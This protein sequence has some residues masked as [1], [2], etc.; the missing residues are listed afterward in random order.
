MKNLFFLWVIGLLILTH[1]AQATN[2]SGTYTV[3]AGGDFT[4]LTAVSNAV[5][6]SSGNQITGNV[7]FEIRSDYNTASETFPIVLRAFTATNPVYTVTIRPRS[8]AGSVLTTGS[9]SSAIISLDEGD[10]YILDGR[11]GGSGSAIW[12]LRNTRSSTTYGAVIRLLNGATYNTMTYLTLESQNATTGSGDIY[13]Q[14]TGNTT[15]NSY[16]T[17]SYCIV[18]NRSDVAGTN[19]TT[20]I[21]ASGNTTYPNTNNTIDNCEF[22][23]HFNAASYSNGIYIY[24]G[25]TAYTITNNKIYQPSTLTYTTGT[26][27]FGIRVYNSAGDGF[28]ISDNTIGFANNSGTGTYTM[29]GAV[30]TQFM[31]IYL[32]LGTG[33]ASSVQGNRIGGISLSSTYSSNNVLSGIYASGM[34][35]IG[36]E[37]GNYIGDTTSATSI[38]V[39]KA[40]ASTSM[41]YVCGILATTASTVN[42]SN[43]CISGITYTSTDATSGLRIFG[44]YST[45]SGGNFTVKANKI[46][47]V[48]TANNIQLGVSGSTTGQGGLMGILNGASGTVT[49]SNNTIANITNYCS[50][51]YYSMGIY[52]FSGLNA[53]NQNQILKIKTYS[54]R[55]GNASSAAVTG[56]VKSSTISGAHSVNQNLIYD[57]SCQ[58][59]T[60]NNYAVGIFYGGPVDGAQEVNRNRI[61][62]L[63]AATTGTTGYA[64]G[65]YVASGNANTERNFIHSLSSTSSTL[66]L[67]GIRIAGGTGSV[68]NNKVQL[69]IDGSGNS[70]TS[71]IY[72]YGIYKSGSSANNVYHNSVY[73]GG[74]GVAST[75]VNTMAFYRSVNTTVDE[76]SNNIFVNNR[77]NS[78]TGGKHF[79]Y[80]LNG[81]STAHCDYNLYHYTGTG[82]YLASLNNGTTSRSTLREVRENYSSQEL[83]SAFGN[84]G[85][86]TPTGT[87]STVDLN[88]SGT[89]AAEASGLN[90]ASVTTDFNGDTRASFSPVD[91]GADAGSFTSSDI[92]TPTVSYL[93][94]N[95]TSS[96]SNRT[97][98]GVTIEDQGTGVPTSGGNV[99]TVWYRIS[100]GTPTAWVYNAGT[101]SSGSGNSGTWSFVIDYSKLSRS[102]ASSDVIQYYIVAQDQATSPNLWYSPFIGASHTSVTSQTTAPSTPNS[103][104]ISSASLSGTYTIGSGGDYATLSAAGGFFATANSNSIS[105]NITLNIISNITE[106]GANALNAMSMGGNSYSIT[107]QPSAAVER[108]ISGSVTT[109]LVRLSGVDSVYIDGSYGGAGRYLRFRNTSTSTSHPACISFTNSSSY[110]KVQNCYL[111]G[112]TNN[113]TIN[114]GAG[115]SVSGNNY[116]TIDNNII[117]NR[118]DLVQNPT[119][120]IYSIGTGTTGLE[121]KENIITNNEIFNY[122]T[123]GVY[124]NGTGNGNHWTIDGN[125][126]YNNLATAPAVA[127]Y[128]IYIGSSNSNNNVITDNYIGGQAASCGGSAYT[129]TGNINFFPIYLYAVGT[130]TKT[131]IDNNTISNISLSSTG[132]A[133]FAGIYVLAGN[134]ACGT[135]NGN[136]IGSAS[137]ASS[138]QIAG[139]GYVVGIRLDAGASTVKKN[140]IANITQTN[141]GPGNLHGM[142]F[143]SISSLTIEKNQIY[144]IGTLSAVTSAYS[145]YGINFASS[146][147]ASAYYVYNNMISLGV[148]SN[149]FSRPIYGIYLNTGSGGDIKMYYNS[150]YITGTASSSTYL[151]TCF[152]KAGAANLNLKN[153]IFFNERTGN[154]SK[155]PAIYFA[156]TS[157]TITSDYNL[158]VGSN[159]SEIGFWG[160][161]RTFAA[162]Q[163]ASTKE[164]FSWSDVSTNLSSA[165]L[166]DGAANGDLDIIND[167]AECWYVNGNGIACTEVS[168]SLSGLSRFTNTADGTTDIGANEFDSA[169]TNEPANATQSGAITVG[170]TTTFTYGGRTI[171]SIYWVSGTALPTSLEAIYYSGEISNVPATN[172]AFNYLQITQTGGTNFKYNITLYYT[173]AMVGQIPDVSSMSIGKSEDGTTWS[174]CAATVNTTAKTITINNMHSFSQFN[175]I[176]EGDCTGCGNFLP[177]E[178]V[179]FNAYKKDLFVKL[180]WATATESNNHFFTIERAEDSKNFLEMA[181]VMGAGNSNEL[182]QYS[183]TDERPI[184]GDNYYRLKQTDYDGQSSYSN[185]VVVKMSSDQK[186]TLYQS[187]DGSLSL[188]FAEGV[189]NAQVE[190][191]DLSGRLLYRNPQVE[192]KSLRIENMPVNQYLFVRITMGSEQKTVKLLSL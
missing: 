49:I 74:S 7:V 142:Y 158:L 175:I 159:A 153:N 69:G 107:I 125:H 12:T 162:Y 176:P 118:S 34:V 123:I 167:N 94:L 88:L 41:T 138:I 97:L 103:Y 31:G 173:D 14:G 184:L 53:I 114:F 141:S 105:G 50:G 140:V 150:V 131:T 77:S 16:N 65:I 145:T 48:T 120:A 89:T 28:T 37:E 164:K 187:P 154:S 64:F 174:E 168:T 20:G 161:Y 5:R 186:V 57:L 3:G 169:P 78:T 100:S 55:A 9:S 81:T 71:A 139:T 106:D 104:S 44:I 152:Y 170:S 4:T 144:K 83:H 160:S 95:N 111:E 185:V 52:S 2:Y 113:Y 98:S 73:I 92:F 109:A 182:T 60:G 156:N 119:Y 75:A 25:N 181:Q 29:D 39:S 36:N 116:N 58:H 80:V 18:R 85:F 91:M 101:L 33:S 96:L 122:V 108:V 115:G 56:I 10:N 46:G 24:T 132:S 17:V 188:Q 11:A 47:S 67:Q 172:P 126:F 1:Q 178:L 87:S 155:N 22:F 135:D 66:N 190:V 6:S 23:N 76:T 149:S 191:I 70:I 189:T 121:N 8:D 51:D 99:P 61:Y 143:A 112:S 86:V 27:H 21:F 59:A 26:M 35:N 72:I 130:A 136:I 110:N 63:T 117:R 15:G 171:A 127:Q 68:V 179:S 165:N 183:Y 13:F 82:G 19:H 151:S 192:A 42:I 79:C 45:G 147:S 163:T 134:V 40:V 102:V 146:S 157:G 148:N 177:I 90:V 32:T 133:N 93:I 128:A 129:N 137:I 84:P 180:D 38:V 62:N 166:F 30:T 54:S 124:L 43:N